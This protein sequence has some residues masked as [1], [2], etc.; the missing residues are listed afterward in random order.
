[1]ARDA[2]K[3]AKKTLVMKE[4]E[5]VER[6]QQMEELKRSWRNYEKEARE[7]GVSRERHIELD[8]DQVCR[9]LP[10]QTKAVFDA[11]LMLG[12]G[13]KRQSDL[14]NQHAECCEGGTGTNT[15]EIHLTNYLWK[16]RNTSP[17][18]ILMHVF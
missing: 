12:D 7:K 3:K 4:Q 1:M 9:C 10:V 14:K 6:K 18:L 11:P 5:L 2:L 8:E 17:S 16:Q 15:Q 13:S